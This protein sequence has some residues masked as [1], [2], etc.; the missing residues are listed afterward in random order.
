MGCG[1][2]TPTLRH[3]PS[4]QVV[5][6]RDKLSLVDCGEGTQLQMRA[7]KVKFMAMRN[8]FISHLHGDH[9]LGLVGLI[10]TFGLLGRTKN[11]HVYAHADLK[12]VLDAQLALFCHKLEFDVEFHPIDSKKHAMIYEDR[13]MEVWTLP[14]SHRMDCCGFLF[15]E[16]PGM[17]H[18]N[19]EMTDFYEIPT[20][21]LNNI[22]AGEDWITPEGKV[23]PNSRL[24]TPPT[25]PRSYAYCSD[26]MYMPELA[27]HIQ[28]V[29]LL[30][31]EATYDNT[32]E[33]K[34]FARGHSTARQAAMIAEMAQ[35]KRLMIGHY[36]ATV[37][38][39]DALLGEAKEV[40]PNSIAAQE[41]LV[42]KI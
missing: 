36:S 9:C 5:N 22:K 28:G 38:D 8:V 4:A 14:L 34:A 21:Y 15:K 11:F 12:P 3:N 17:P 20:C 25:P 23:I 27:K 13:T 10:S 41:G 1:S 29:D 32:K 35:V 24:T 19:R 31:H 40:F 33:A 30:Y 39:I 26:T 37:E 18:I 6:M 7:R 42:V 16:K 2:A